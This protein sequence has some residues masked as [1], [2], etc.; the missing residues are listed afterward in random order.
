MDRSKLRKVKIL[1]GV[2]KDNIGYFHGFFQYG[3]EDG[4]TPV[5]IVELASGYVINVFIS[6]I[7]FINEN[8]IEYKI[9]K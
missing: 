7:K 3:D 5:A 9:S 8:K 2:Y 6:D 4:Q 1:N